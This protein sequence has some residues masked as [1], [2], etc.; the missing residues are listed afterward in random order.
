MVRTRPTYS[1]IN[2]RG[3]ILLYILLSILTILFSHSFFGDTLQDGRPPSIL[4]SIVFFT[5]PVVLLVFMAF[6]LVRLLRDTILRRRGNKFQTRLMGYFI[7]TVALAAAPVTIITIQSVY[8]LVRFWRS[9]NINNAIQYAQNVAMENYSMHLS[10]KS[11][12]LKRIST[13]S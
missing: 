8:E 11:L 5:V 3:L 13:P 12:P 6:S 4:N 10:S 7:I 2:V 1:I 9:V